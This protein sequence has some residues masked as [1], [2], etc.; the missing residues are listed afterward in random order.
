MENGNKKKTCTQCGTLLKESAKF[1]SKCGQVAV[2]I[3]NEIEQKEPLKKTCTQCGELLKETA[4]FCPKCGQVIGEAVKNNEENANLNTNVTANTINSIPNTEKK[5]T[6]K[7]FLI[8]VAIMFLA[9][10]VGGIGVILSG[11]KSSA[12][13]VGDALGRDSMQIFLAENDYVN[14]PSGMYESPDKQVGVYLNEKG[15]P[16]QVI[17]GGGNTK[18]FGI[19][20][21]D[22]FTLE[23]TGRALTTRGYGYVSE[24]EM[25]ITY[26]TEIPGGFTKSITLFLGVEDNKIYSIIYTLSDDSKTVEGNE[27]TAI[28]DEGLSA[29]DFLEENGIAYNVLKDT[30]LWEDMKESVVVC[31][32]KKNESI[33]VT[34]DCGNG[35]FY[36]IYGDNSGFIRGENFESAD[37]DMPAGLSEAYGEESTEAAE[38]NDTNAPQMMLEESSS[39]SLTDADVYGMTPEQLRIAINEIY[40][41]HGRRFNDAELQAWFDAQSWYYGTVLPDQ[42]D[43]SRLSQIEK[44]NIKFLQRKRDGKSTIVEKALSGKYQVKFGNEG[45]AELEIVYGSGDDVYSTE[46][47]G[48]YL[49]YAGGTSGYLVEFTAGVWDYY[50]DGS[51]SPSMRL[52]YDG[53]DTITVTSLDGA[54]F[55]GAEFP[56]FEETY[57]RTAEYSMP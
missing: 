5:K 10:A 29:D 12:V 55:G 15:I 3:E 43:E 40:A 37:E 36:A 34:D 6:K 47:S 1:C 17:I 27:K 20:I 49:D 28:G 13:D 16:E 22:T 45:G 42:F 51:Y 46:F 7:V 30:F 53:A 9:V 56:G 39:R 33:I 31:E 48:S 14:D 25:S 11:S 44:D 57:Y 26:A 24:D 8:L 21:G 35:W 54:S 32:V 23:K 18:I 38:A 19:G 41:R 50:E 4:K 52:N 2:S